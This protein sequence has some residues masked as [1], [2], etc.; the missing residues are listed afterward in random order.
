MVYISLIYQ[1]N[2]NLKGNLS[3][4]RKA[5]KHLGSKANK[6]E[7]DLNFTISAKKSKLISAS[8]K[9]YGNW[10]AGA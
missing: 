5:N 10:F 7:H 3:F 8:K 1:V 2:F 4:K 6:I 9:Y